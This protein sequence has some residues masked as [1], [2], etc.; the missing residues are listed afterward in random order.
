VCASL[1]AIGAE[2]VPDFRDRALIRQ[3]SG[4]YGQAI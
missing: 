4:V 1:V 3:T 2:H